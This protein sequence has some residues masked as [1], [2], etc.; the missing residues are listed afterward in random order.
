MK[1]LSQCDRGLRAVPRNT[2]LASQ[3]S[4]WPSLGNWKLTCLKPHRLL[5]TPP[6]APTTNNV[7]PTLIR[8][9]TR[10]IIPPSYFGFP[11]LQLSISSYSPTEIYHSAPH[12]KS[13]L[14]PTPLRRKPL[15][16]LPPRIRPLMS[17]PPAPIRVPANTFCSA[18]GTK[19]LP[20]PRPLLPKRQP[21]N[22]LTVKSPSLD[23]PT[24]IY[25]V[26]IHDSDE[27]FVIG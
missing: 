20:P 23:D 18:R 24:L 8:T 21:A 26:S 7:H 17:L 1:I 27:E 22:P 13:P 9:H 15:L 5:P 4:D 2:C 11:I 10:D 14:L 16:P 6:P 25:L 12:P 19:A 3:A